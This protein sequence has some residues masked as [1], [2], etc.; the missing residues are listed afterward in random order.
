MVAP[1]PRLPDY[2]P[3]LQ[4]AQ[5]P[6]PLQLLERLSQRLGGPRIWVK[7]DDLTGCA[8]TGNKVRKLE[9]ILAAAM[10]DGADT[11]ITCGGVQSNHCRAT[12]LLC[13]RLGLRCH[14]LLRGAA[15]DDLDGNLLL[16][17]LAGA[18]IRYVEA[19]RYLREL[20]AL[21]EEEADRVRASGGRPFIVPT[22]G[23]DAI[24]LW[25]HVA[26]CEELAA[27]FAA[28]GIAPGHLVCATGSGGTQA[29]L[30]AGAL[31][32]GLNA[33]VWGMAVCNDA[34]W[35]RDKIRQDLAAWSER[36]GVGLDPEGIPVEVIDDYIGPGYARADEAVFD[37]MV[38]LA[39]SEG[40]L[41]DPVYTGKAFHGLLC[42]YRQGR[43]DDSDDLVFLHTGGLFGLFPQRDRL[44]FNAE[45]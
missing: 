25:G 32:H 18:R 42:E 3:R 27:D 10:A 37:T 13:A 17:H 12:A 8:E 5:R 36:Y 35:F 38:E 33:R 41:L 45:G 15:E 34:A 44:V 26:V 29:G 30:V 28:Q 43:F 4:L 1:G 9:F 2:P 31:F 40:L 14:L 6:T 22:G 7:R 24:G 16:D 23:S 11:L 21:L 20:P 39:R 19:P